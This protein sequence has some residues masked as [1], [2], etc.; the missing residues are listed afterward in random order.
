MYQTPMQHEGLRSRHHQG[1]DSPLHMSGCVNP[2]DAPCSR[3]CD[4][5]AIPT[6]VIDDPVPLPPARHVQLE[7]DRVLFTGRL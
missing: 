4:P 2:S 5:P 7:H 6:L 3:M 1:R